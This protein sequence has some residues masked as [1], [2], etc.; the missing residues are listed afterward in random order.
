MTF[1]LFL[2]GFCLPHT[3]FFGPQTF[4]GTRKV[5]VGWNKPRTILELPWTNKFPG[6]FL[7]AKLEK[8]GRIG[9]FRVGRQRGLGQGGV[10]LVFPVSNKIAS[11]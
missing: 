5:S 3:F 9:D 10:L 2:P 8:S 1:A 6:I 7:R 4:T 11:Q